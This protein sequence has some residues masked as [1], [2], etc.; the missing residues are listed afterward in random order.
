MNSN[1]HVRV[2]IVEDSP[3]QAAQLRRTLQD[4]DFD[5]V[6]ASNAS[7]AMEVLRRDRPTL[8]IS[9]VIMPGMSGYE[10]CA[11]IKAD[12]ALRDLPVILLT[13]LSDPK[14]VIKGLKCGADSFIVKPYEDQALLSRIQYLLANFELRQRSGSNAGIEILFA[15]ERH[16][17]RSE[18]MQV[19]DL[20]LSTYE[21]AVQ[22]NL[23]LTGAKEEAERANHAKSEFL[24]GMSHELRTPM[25]AILGFAQL[26]ELDETDKDKRDSLEHIL[27][28]GNHLLG[29]IN[30]VLDVA[31]LDAGRLELSLEAIDLRE[32]LP[33]TIALLQPLAAKRNIQ[34]TVIA[35][36]TPAYTVLADR[37]RLRQVLLN[38]VSNAIKYNRAGG[39][40]T[41]AS[42]EVEPRKMRIVVSDTGA[43][44]SAADLQRLFVPFERLDAG[45]T[46]IQGA[47]LGLALSKGLVEAMGGSIDVKSTLGQGTSFSVQLAMSAAQPAEQTQSQST[48]P[49]CLRNVLCIEDDPAFLDV[50]N[51]ILQCRPEVKL[52]TA[53]DAARGLELARRERFDSILLDY[54]L[55]DMKGHEVFRLLQ[56]DPRTA[57]IPV[58]VISGDDDPAKIKRLFATGAPAYL[59]KPFRVPE[60]FAVFD[61]ALERREAT[62]APAN[63]SFDE[64]YPK[65]K[66]L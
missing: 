59:A 8:L 49:S 36:E 42:E 48:Q 30:E 57:G 62:T 61:E 2:L 32:L 44:I 60:F 19:I 39:S 53:P 50:L 63:F 10:L 12:E 6:A 64:K 15:G 40:V 3:T 52:T 51:E 66:L 55:P 43:G 31:R 56:S 58:V 13:E 27:T 21:T 14:D 34:V 20:L 24:T 17:I 5:V 4:H 11:A 25:N 28:A 38:M 22:K 7:E 54:H 23:A 46:D 47:G 37:Q 65:R 45:R 33:E 16:L 26:L 1:T 9:D 18:R 41:I 35:A 29:L